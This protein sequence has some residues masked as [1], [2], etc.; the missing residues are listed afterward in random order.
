[1]VMYLELL[2]TRQLCLLY[3]RVRRQTRDADNRQNTFK[4]I[5]PI[6]FPMIRL[7]SLIRERLTVTRIHCQM[8]SI[9]KTRT[10]MEKIGYQK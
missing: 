6:D 1:M 5:S 4:N 2:C 8:L 7:N 3:G 9:K 10:C